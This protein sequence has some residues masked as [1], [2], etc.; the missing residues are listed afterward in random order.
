MKVICIWALTQTTHNHGALTRRRAGCRSES[1]IPLA[2][3]SSSCA[4]NPAGRLIPMG[5]LRTWFQYAYLFYR[6][7]AHRARRGRRL[8]RRQHGR[9]QRGEAGWSD[10][11]GCRRSCRRRRR[12]GWRHR[13]AHQDRTG[14]ESPAPAALGAKCS[15][16]R[17][18][19]K[20]HASSNS[21]CLNIILLTH[22]FPGRDRRPA[23]G[24]PDQRAGRAQGRA[25]SRCR[26]GRGESCP[27]ANSEAGGSPVPV[28]MW[29]GVSPVPVQMWQGVSPVPVQMWQGVSPVPVQMWQGVSPVPVQM[30]QG[31]S[32]VP[33]QMWQ[34]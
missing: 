32:P 22:F 24:R 4:A 7:G 11:R 2:E 9:Q 30:W 8:L 29:Q 23:S 19:V 10:R 18:C 6:E 17:G 20:A 28:Q 21:H 14:W 33:V 25:Q 15:T 26:R 34:G 31:V 27:G 12:S 16:Q 3:L 1:D 5:A 13:P